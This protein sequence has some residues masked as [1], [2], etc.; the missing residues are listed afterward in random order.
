MRTL[1]TTVIL[2]ASSMQL[3]A[4]EEN[5]IDIS[6]FD[7]ARVLQAL[8]YQT[9]P[10]VMGIAHYD[11]NYKLN[12]EDAKII[13]QRNNGKIGYLHGRL[14]KIDLSGNVL[15]V[16]RFNY[17]NGAGVAQAAIQDMD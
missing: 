3:I 6:R 8:F 9:K 11:S 5:K 13:L 14:L 1:I 16:G 2:M 7:K 4:M 12:I 17:Y 10:Q 15:D